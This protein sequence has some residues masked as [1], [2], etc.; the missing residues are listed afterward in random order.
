[1]TPAFERAFE[2]VVGREG[3]F[4]DDPED[5]GNWT[6]GQIG[7]GE[8]KGTKYGI[9]AMSY[10]ELDIKNLTLDQAKAIYWHDYWQR[11]MADTMPA[12]IGLAMFD[13]AVNQGVH[14]VIPCLQRAVGVAPDGKFGPTTRAAVARTPHTTLV[15]N[16][17]AERVL[18]YTEA[19]GWPRYKRGWARRAV[20]TAI[21]AAR[22]GA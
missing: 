7:V 13:C 5:R 19:R 4:D 21:L 9:S 6:S 11:I 15:E 1:M 16:F 3:E 17:Q 18:E 10:P 14:R 20:G 2:Y 12:G 22:T 8:L